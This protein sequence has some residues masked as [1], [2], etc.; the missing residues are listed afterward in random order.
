[1]NIALILR[2]LSTG[3]GI[4]RVA[5]AHAAEF[6]RLGHETHIYAARLLLSDEERK[7]LPPGIVLRRFP[8]LRGSPR[9]WTIP[10][11]A[12]RPYL[13]ARHD[14]VVSHLLTVW[15]DVIVMHNDPQPVEAEKL[16]SA[17]FT[18]DRP[19]VRTGNRL[20]RDFIE[21]RRFSPSRYKRVVAL[22]QRSAA[23]ISGVCGVP[24][25]NIT[26]IRNGVDA[27]RFSPA[28]RLAGRRAARESFGLSA[29]E[30]VFL[31]VGDSWKGL[32]F[33]IKGIAEARLGKAVLVAAGPFRE[34]K[35]RPLAAALGLRL[36]CL[37]GRPDIRDL[38]SA[39]DALINPTPI[40]TFGLAVLEA[41]A[42][43]LPVITTEQSG[44]SELLT[45]GQDAFIVKKAWDTAAIA[46]T[47]SRLASPS[48]RGVIGERAA[49]RAAG[50]SWEEPAARHLE[51]YR[52]IKTSSVN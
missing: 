13:N 23:E 15:Q 11:G 38:Y 27:S 3:N 26:V 25:E 52:K 16:L 33:A 8:C 44:V 29:G 14:V 51:L 28:H 2:A 10:F 35:F 31:Y 50:L 45:D 36:I 48:F 41:M 20:I 21:R 4:S 18:V 30:T 24:R 46:D 32:E 39:A 37:G 34:E 47:A 7:A 12:L 6:A 42:M 17:P 40:D 9:I 5:L 43:G 22:S 49:A 19:R 1:M